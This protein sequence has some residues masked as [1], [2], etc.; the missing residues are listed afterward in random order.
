MGKSQGKGYQSSLAKVESAQHSVHPTRESR[1]AKSII[2]IKEGC[3]A[4]ARVT[5][6]V[7][8]ALGK[9]RCFM[10]EIKI[11]NWYTYCCQK[12]LAQIETQEEIEQIMQ[13]I[14][15]DFGVDI[16]ET[17]LEALQDIRE[18]WVRSL[19]LNG[20]SNPE[21]YQS[22]IDECDEMLRGLTKRAPDAG[23]SSQ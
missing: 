20:G 4:R 11:G 3:E 7:S 18:S 23:D 1:G 16:Y 10:A 9:E 12:D 8:P 19:A 6:T 14:S 21:D 22:E 5:Q 13:L 17:Q 2:Q 15:D